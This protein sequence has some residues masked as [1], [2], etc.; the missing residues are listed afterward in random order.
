MAKPTR[1]QAAETTIRAL[2]GAFGHKPSRPI[3]R[4]DTSRDDT[5]AVS[6]YGTRGYLE[7]TLSYNDALKLRKSEGPVNEHNF[8]AL[9]LAGIRLRDGR[10]LRTT[11]ARFESEV[12]T[13]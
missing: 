12:S 7:K 5:S 6:L 11:D 2:A 13:W 1:K 3:A 10:I 4:K 9:L 8:A